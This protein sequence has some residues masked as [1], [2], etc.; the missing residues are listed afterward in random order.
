MNDFLSNFASSA[1]VSE[2]EF[3]DYYADVSMTVIHDHEFA[4]ILENTWG[5]FEDE[6][7][8]VTKQ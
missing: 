3:I 8:S 6:E 7:A 4:K 2:Q 1:L 5:V